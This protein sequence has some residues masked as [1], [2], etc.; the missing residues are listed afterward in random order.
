MKNQAQ[1]EYQFGENIAKFDMTSE[2]VSSLGNPLLPKKFLWEFLRDGRTPARA[3]ADLSMERLLVAL[4]GPGKILE[5]G[6]GGSY[7]KNFV[8]EDQ[9]YI[10][11]NFVPGCDVELNMTNLELDDD[12]ID[13]IVSVF[14]IEHL[15][16]FNAVFAEQ[17]RVLKP[18]GRILIM[19]PFLYYY[20]SA[21]DDFFRFS[22][23]A[24]DRLFGSFN[25]L[26]R[27]PIGNRCLLVAES[28]HEKKVMGSNLGFFGRLAL[29]CITLPFLL[30][31]LGSHDSKY[32]IGFTYICEKPI[33]ETP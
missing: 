25:I 10:T 15:Y 3:A 7:Y 19:A 6:A 13:A 27:Q 12:S 30:A 14:A 1:T 28:F 29:R 2:N 21:P 31:G 20:H 22:A 32:A 11:S 4:Y 33:R 24:L 23:S 8:P 18:G 9:N 26:L 5:L 16:D 17:K